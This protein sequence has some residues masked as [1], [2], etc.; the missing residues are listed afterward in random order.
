MACVYVV[1]LNFRGILWSRGLA[2]YSLWATSGL[3]SVSVW[4]ER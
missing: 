4:P 2:N 1:E 3:L